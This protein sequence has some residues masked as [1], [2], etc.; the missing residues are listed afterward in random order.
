MSVKETLLSSAQVAETCLRSGESG[1]NESLDLSGTLL[2]DRY[3]VVRRLGSGGMGTVYLAE[4]I[5]LRKSFAVKVLSTDFWS[6]RS[7]VDRFL[8]EARTASLIQ[9]HN[10]VEITDFGYAEDKVPFL[11]MELLEGDEL[12]DVIRRDGAMAWPRVRVLMLQILAALEAAHERGIIHRDMKPQNCFC[13]HRSDG[14]LIVKVLDFGIAKVINDDVDFKTLTRPGT[15]MGTPHYMSPE[16]ANSEVLDVR[17]DVYSAGVI[18]FELLTGHVP[19]QARGF[20]GVLSKVLTEDIP[21]MASVA[22]EAKVHPKVEAIVRRAMAKDRN[23]RH[24]TAAEFAA[25]IRALPDD[26]GATRATRAPL[27]I[28]AGVLVSVLGVLALVA[29][30]DPALE[31]N[32][33]AD[34]VPEAPSLASQPEMPP[35]PQPEP[36][37][38]PSPEPPAVAPSVAVEEAP[39]SP[40]PPKTSAKT[41]KKGKSTPSIV[42]ETTDELPDRPSNADIDAALAPARTAARA[43]RE[44]HKTLIRSVKVELTVTPEG[45]VA[46]ARAVSSEQGNPVATCVEKAASGSSFPPSRLGFVQTVEIS[47]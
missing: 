40:A 30:G 15:V 18:A 14:E 31:A 46:K 12:G 13:V 3:R 1:T 5:V 33:H 26:L 47:L 29:G 6:K 42:S 25:A 23:E 9:H 39:A 22:P 32:P 19:F 36:T 38:E 24:A 28:G 2:A 41:S 27:W 16:Q 10:V 11:V 35:E 45:E 7:S 34:A 4:H 8:Q 20:L 21:S 37:R 43:C 17:A 44:Q